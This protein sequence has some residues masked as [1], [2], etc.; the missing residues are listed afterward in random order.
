MCIGDGTN[1]GV[2]EVIGHNARGASRGLSE[3]RVAETELLEQESVVPKHAGGML[4]ARERCNRVGLEITVVR[5][6]TI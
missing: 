6:G 5:R 1:R 4:R 3:A 2:H